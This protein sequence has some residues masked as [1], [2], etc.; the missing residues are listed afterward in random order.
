MAIVRYTTET[1]PPV[2]DKDHQR[3]AA[4]REEDIDCSDI[5]EIKDFSAFRPLANR[6]HYKPA[7]VAVACKLDA[8]IIAWLKRDG[9]GYQ[10]RLNAILRKEMIAAR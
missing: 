5:G 7:K 2:S 8:D 6:R 3:A 10:R 1:L 4:I 9:N